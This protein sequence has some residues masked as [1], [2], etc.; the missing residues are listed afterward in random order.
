MATHSALLAQCRACDNLSLLGRLINPVKYHTLALPAS[1]PKKTKISC[2]PLPSTSDAGTVT[3]KR[4]S[5]QSGCDRT[6]SAWDNLEKKDSVLLQ[7]PD[8]T[9][10]S[11]KH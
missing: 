5:G 6:I 8:L 2:T 7:S 1:Q 9:E 4:S 3:G 10:I 11:A